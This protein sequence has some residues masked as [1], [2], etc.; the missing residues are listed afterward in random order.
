[1]DGE[2]QSHGVGPGSE[3]TGTDPGGPLHA[4]AAL[5]SDGDFAGARS[6]LLGAT[7]ESPASAP[8]WK[9]LGVA[10]GKLGDPVAA[11]RALHRSLE[12][13]ST[14]RDAW[15]SLGGVLLA[16]GRYDQAQDCFHRGV[17]L[18]DD[19][20][21]T[22]ALLNFLTLAAR[23]PGGDLDLAPYARE[24]ALGEAAC[25]AQLAAAENLPWAGFDLA[26]LR[27]FTG[28]VDEARAALRD[29]LAVAR[30]WQAASARAPYELLAGSGGSW[31]AAARQMLAELGDAGGP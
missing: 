19:V 14:D 24:L 7:A 16:A 9:L 2:Q 17:D 5:I 26:Q 29:A 21:D 6:L 4:A 18:A 1:V 30:P 8:A 15:S 13:D 11:E 22:Y 28:R 20:P 23:G 31:A 12:L 27:F 25:V 3:R 10:E